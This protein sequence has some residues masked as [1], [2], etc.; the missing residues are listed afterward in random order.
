MEQRRCFGTV[1]LAAGMCAVLL[2]GCGTS[3]EI[4]LF[5]GEPV[6][7]YSAEQTES[8]VDEHQEMLYSWQQ[9]IE[10]TIKDEPIMTDILKKLKEASGGVNDVGY[11]VELNIV[12]FEVKGSRDDND[13]VRNDMMTVCAEE[14]EQLLQIL[15]EKG[16]GY[17][18]ATIEYSNGSST[19]SHSFDL[20]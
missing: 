17:P 16:V 13:A 4:D 3:E 8:S 11:R 18:C 20:E 9:I 10:E 12:Y 7:E 14:I 1:L 5:R 6:I 15:K 19:G 2:A